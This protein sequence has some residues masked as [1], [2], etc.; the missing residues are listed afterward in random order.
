K[1][2]DQIAVQE[3][4]WNCG[5]D[6]F[7]NHKHNPFAD[8]RVRR[9]LSL[10]ID[11]WGGAQ[12]LSKIAIVKAVGGIVFPSSPLAPGEQQLHEIAGFWTDINKSREEAKRLLKEAGAENLSFELLNRDVDQPYKYI[13][14]WLVDQWSKIGV[15]VTQKIVPSGP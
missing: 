5:S 13:G 14:I 6:L 9:S 11:R 10:A 8:P 1:L 15:K 12:A 3:S 4:V 7:Y 2:G